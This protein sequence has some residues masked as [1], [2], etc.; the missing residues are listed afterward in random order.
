MAE[1]WS[2]KTSPT[3]PSSAIQWSSG[4]VSDGIYFTKITIGTDK[5]TYTN[6]LGDTDVY[7][8]SAWVKDNYR[9]VAFINSPSGTLL[10]WLNANAIKLVTSTKTISYDN[11]T[12]FK[13]LMDSKIEEKLDKKLDKA[14]NTTQDSVYGV[15]V[16]KGIEPFQTESVLN[17]TS[18]YGPTTIGAQVLKYKTII[19]LVGNGYTRIMKNYEILNNKITVTPNSGDPGLIAFRF[20]C[21]PGAKFKLNYSGTNILFASAQVFTADGTRL[22]QLT[23]N[24]YNNST[25]TIPSDYEQDPVYGMLTI[26][27]STAGQDL[28]INTLSLNPLDASLSQVMY[29]I[30][31]NAV[32]NTLVE[33][34]G[35]CEVKT[36][37]PTEADSAANKEYVDTS[38]KGVTVMVTD[39]RSGS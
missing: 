25:I 38:V 21:T 10:T 11:L 4:F 1:T 32:A 16:T 9:T 19:G 20:T 31:D 39:L 6:S 22:G 3:L 18:Q 8:S 15:S 34:N 30:S 36:A 26:Q 5:I 13:A 7:T 24:Y 23:T 17:P 14:V 35:K 28:V 37:V 12:V 2:I 27:G 29:I 33:R